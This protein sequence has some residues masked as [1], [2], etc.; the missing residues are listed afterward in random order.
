MH[1]MTFLPMSQVQFEELKKESTKD[2]TTQ[3]LSATIISGWPD[4]KS[5]LPTNLHPYYSIW[6]ELSVHEGVVFKGQRAVIPFTMQAK[7]KDKV[8]AAHMGIQGCLRRARETIYW[9]GMNK[10]LT[11]FIA[12]CDIC[13]SYQ[14]SA[15]AKESK[16]LQ[17]KESKSLQA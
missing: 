9:P 3:Q 10:D 16:S 15:Q 14:D 6:D 8:H 4:D 2:D 11:N 12:K 1:A 5:K 7:M 13:A 17:A